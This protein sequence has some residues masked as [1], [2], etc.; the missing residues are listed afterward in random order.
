MQPSR[1]ADAAL[2]ERFEQP[3][4][5]SSAAPLDHLLSLD[6]LVKAFRIE[7][8]DPVIEPGIPRDRPG[9]RGLVSGAANPVDSTPAALRP[10]PVGPVGDEQRAVAIDH[11]VGRLEA[12]GIV[13]RPGGELLLHE[14]CETAALAS[15]SAGD[16][17]AAPLAEE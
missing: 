9:H 2:A 17:G 10:L 3:L 16:D 6:A 5:T 13:T 11:Q 14:R 1:H 15:R 8:R 7:L 12:V 4:H